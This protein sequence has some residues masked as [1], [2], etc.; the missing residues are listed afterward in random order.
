[1][2]TAKTFV[3]RK[4]RIYLPCATF[5]LCESKSKGRVCS[6][7]ERRLREFFESARL[8]GYVLED[9]FVSEIPSR[10]SKRH[11]L[12]SE[13]LEAEHRE[14]PAERIAHDFAS[15]LPD[16]LRHFSELSV[17]VIIESNGH[18]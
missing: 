18:S 9:I 5:A 3:P 13:L 2:Q 10:L 16:G 1:M 4:T 12:F 11:D 7:G 15:A 8:S 14:L 6:E 17:K